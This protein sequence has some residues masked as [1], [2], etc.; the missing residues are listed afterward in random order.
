MD[1]RKRRILGTLIDDYIVSAEPVGSRTLAKKY[2]LGISSATIR[3]EMA[4]LE[5]L[6][7]LEQPHTSAGRIPSDRGYRY[8][9]DELMQRPQV[10]S[11]TVNRVRMAFAAPV[12]EIAWFIH[13]TAQM[14]SDMTAYPSVVVAPPVNDARLGDIRVMQLNAGTL[15]LVV[16]TDSGMVENRAV[17]LP[18]DMNFEQV[19]WLATEFAREF[20]GMPIK[21]L[22]DRI[23]D[24]LASDEERYHGL[25]ES[26]LA[27]MSDWRTNDDRVTLAGSLNILRYPEFRDV[28]KVERVLGFLEREQAVEQLLQGTSPLSEQVHVI[29]GQESPFD[30]IWDCSVVTATYQLRGH[31]VG[32]VSVIGPKRMQYAHV[33]T[34]LEIVSEELSRALKWA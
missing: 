27:W 12:R 3:N 29:I 31:I 4:D 28:G 16:A 11:D 32:Q 33:V 13:Q 24:P 6:G 7:F 19:A 25:W 9:V 34:T 30:A 17:P 18:E 10:G 8:Y 15:L 14:V 21:E 2:G 22:K 26:L 23:L 1:A 5:E 20:R